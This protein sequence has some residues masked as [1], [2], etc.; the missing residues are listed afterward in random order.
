MIGCRWRS[1]RFRTGV[2]GADAED[3]GADAEDLREDWTNVTLLFVAAKD[4]MVVE[5]QSTAKNM[6]N[7]HQSKTR[8][9]NNE[10]P[11]SIHQYFM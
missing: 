1:H 9:F 5:V 10:C 11:S 3:L 8:V 7:K 4:P 2:H 6:S